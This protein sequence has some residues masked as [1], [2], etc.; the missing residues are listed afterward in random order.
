M[1]IGIA[2]GLGWFAAAIVSHFIVLWTKAPSVRPRISQLIFFS[3]AAGTLLTLILL[4]PDLYKLAYCALAAILTYGALLTLYLPFYYSIVASLS[5]QT[6]ILLSDQ[7]N[8]QLPIENLR[9]KFSSYELVA[10]RLATMANNGFVLER[11]R[12][13][14]LTAKGRRIARIFLFFKNF[15]RLGAGG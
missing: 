14:S 10:Q 2:T 15:W 5:L 4:S 12:R 6:I 7:T 9:H 11:D 13:Y 8:G 3:G 1:E